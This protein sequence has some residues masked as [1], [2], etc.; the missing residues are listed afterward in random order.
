M[1]RLRSRLF[2]WSKDSGG[3]T[4]MEYGLIA[5]G[6]ACAAFG[7]ML[8]TGDSLESILNTGSEIFAGIVADSGF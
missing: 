1:I 6:V 4:A 7:A 3:A 2:V 8:L 5:T